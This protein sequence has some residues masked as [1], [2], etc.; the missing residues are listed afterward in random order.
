[1]F[2]SDDRFQ[3]L[4]TSVRKS[5]GHVLQSLTLQPHKLS[6]EPCKLWFTPP[7]QAEC[8]VKLSSTSSWASGSFLLQCSSANISHTH[9]ARPLEVKT[10]EKAKENKTEESKSRQAPMPAASNATPAPNP[11]QNTAPPPS[12]PMSHIQSIYQNYKKQE[13]ELIRIRE[14]I[15]LLSSKGRSQEA[16]ALKK[17]AE[18]KVTNLNHLRQ[19]IANILQQK[20]ATAGNQSSTTVPGTTS[21]GTTTTSNNQT[22]TTG[23]SQASPM[24]RTQQQPQANSQPGDVG[25]INPPAGLPGNMPLNA[26]LAAQMQKLVGREGIQ[27]TTLMSSMAQKAQEIAQ[28]KQNSVNQSAAYTTPLSEAQSQ[29]T[30]NAR[31]PKKWV[32]TLVWQSPQTGERKRAVV[33]CLGNSD[34]CAWNY[35]SVMP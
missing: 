16:N 33:E 18:P 17:A 1:M 34:M 27:G 28:Q 22:A 7:L 14:Q 6:P 12:V 20:H 35:C 5:F 9:L 23:P 3:E 31:D 4:H 8:S 29:P 11:P 32:G 30:N 10:E 24:T 21:S 25:Q 13:E 2:K 26:S 15:L 19:T